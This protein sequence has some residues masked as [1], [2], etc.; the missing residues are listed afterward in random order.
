MGGPA[1]SHSMSGVQP[2][3]SLEGFSVGFVH[4]LP[5]SGM[6]MMGPGMMGGPPM[7]PMGMPP[8][9]GPPMGPMGHPGMMMGPPPMHPGMMHH[10]GMM[11][12]PGMMMGPGGPMA[13]PMPPMM[14]GVDAESHL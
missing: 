13:P 3:L 9:M 8:F 11:G 1:A 14:M 10:P 6:G 2:L 5:G 12:P 7:G 4:C